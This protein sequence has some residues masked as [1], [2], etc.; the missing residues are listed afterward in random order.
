[1]LHPD[2]PLKIIP[3]NFGV[4]FNPPKLGL[5]YKPIDQPM[6]QLIYEIALQPHLD[7][8]LNTDDIVQT[9]FSEHNQY[10][11][12]KVIAKSQLRKLVDRVVERA[13]K[14]E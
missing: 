5:E 13:K 6:T 12:P 4:K 10:L 7:R 8:G 1:M 2:Y 14:L 11:H 9:L 3:V